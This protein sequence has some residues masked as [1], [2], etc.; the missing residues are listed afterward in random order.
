MKGN[1]SRILS[2]GAKAAGKGGMAKAWT[3][4]R[5]GNNHCW[6]V[7]SGRQRPL[8]SSNAAP[9]HQPLA[10]PSCL[11]RLGSPHTRHVGGGI[12]GLAL[13]AAASHSDKCRPKAQLI[14]HSRAVRWLLFD[15][16]TVGNSGSQGPGLPKATQMTE[17]GLTGFESRPEE[18]TSSP[19][20]GCSLG[21]STQW[22]EAQTG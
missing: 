12:P 9:H 4:G 2:R 5:A 17:P 22:R 1:P 14:Q 3:L 19:Q 11:L 10:S 6:A 18:Q 16:F 15:P 8:S 13:T 21:H 7:S 20:M